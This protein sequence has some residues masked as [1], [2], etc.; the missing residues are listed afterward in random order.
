[1]AAGLMMPPCTPCAAHRHLPEQ[2]GAG[3]G[4]HFFPLQPLSLFA[5]IQG[6]QQ[7]GSLSPL[8]AVSTSGSKASLEGS[9]Q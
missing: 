9:V 8:W 6:N 5:S 4:R 1:M 2:L 7:K 3:S